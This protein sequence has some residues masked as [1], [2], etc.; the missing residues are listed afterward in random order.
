MLNTV[1]KLRTTLATEGFQLVEV[2]RDG[3]CLFSSIASQL[4]MFHIPAS[5]TT[6]HHQVV[7]FICQ[8]PISAKSFIATKHTDILMTDS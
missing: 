3:N 7:E 8:N 4:Q 6:V 1:D 2:P 5:A